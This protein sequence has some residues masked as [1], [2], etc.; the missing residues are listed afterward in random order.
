MHAPYE[1]VS[2]ADIFEMYK[3]YKAFYTILIYKYKKDK[4]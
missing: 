2:K 1:I 4:C 3:G